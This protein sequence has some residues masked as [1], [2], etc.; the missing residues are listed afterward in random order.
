MKNCAFE[1]TTLT[2]LM[3][4]AMTLSACG[5]SYN[6]LS[7][8]A[9][10]Q[11]RE[12]G[13]VGSYHFAEGSVICTALEFNDEYGI[14]LPIRGEL[15]EW[16]WVSTP[17]DV[18]PE[19]EEFD[20]DI[21]DYDLDAIAFLPTQSG[22]YVLS[23]HYSCDGALI[24]A[25]IEIT[26]VD[27]EPLFK[28]RHILSASESAPYLKLHDFI[29]ADVS[30]AYLV[31]DLD[32]DGNDDVLLRSGAS[33]TELRV[34]SVVGDAL[35]ACRDILAQ[36]IPSHYDNIAAIYGALHRDNELFVYAKMT[37]PTTGA[38]TVLRLDMDVLEATFVRTMNYSYNMFG[39]V[40]DLAGNGLPTFL[41]TT[42][43]W[44]IDWMVSFD[45]DGDPS[46]T[47]MDTAFVGTFLE[48]AD[49]DE[50]G[51]DEMLFR[52][53]EDRIVVVEFY[54]GGERI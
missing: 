26:V 30:D 20:L 54:E 9:R 51:E 50:D 18:Q 37:G 19:T 25:E 28:I 8:R 35:E 39:P 32:D 33:G 3:I 6:E 29:S 31:Q 24:P 14:S 11:T 4:V 22:T 44:L 15:V 10:I 23:A 34:C 2:A 47:A 38:A 52:F 48:F 45:E 7:D 1:L 21:W 46:E 12:T 5:F 49:Y 40:L 17:D 42:N 13:Y 16:K 27:D 53:D 43:G 41:S 36:L